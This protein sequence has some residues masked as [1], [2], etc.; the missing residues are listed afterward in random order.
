M[1]DR[2]R[3]LIVVLACLTGLA[4][5]HYCEKQSDSI[6]ST[7]T[8]IDEHENERAIFRLKDDS[9]SHERTVM[10]LDIA[11][12]NQVL[13]SKKTRHKEV[14]KEIETIKPNLTDSV[15][16]IIVKFEAVTD[17]VI[18]SQDSIIKKHTELEKVLE[19]NLLLKDDMIKK[20]S[21]TIKELDDNF[22]NQL[23]KEKF[24]RF[25]LIGGYFVAITLAVLFLK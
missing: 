24:K 25:K 16:T 21:V 18:N 1:Q 12:A 14:K 10:V 8:I 22:K 4:L 6:T 5:C 23:R 11:K 13:K 7:S 3:V 9:L 2:N 17:S 20:D 19:A 15:K